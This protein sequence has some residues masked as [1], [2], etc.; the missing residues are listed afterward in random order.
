[1]GRRGTPDDHQ[2]RWVWL[3]GQFGDGFAKTTAEPSQNGTFWCK[4]KNGPHKL[5]AQPP[6]CTGSTPCVPNGSSVSPGGTRLPC[7]GCARGGLLHP[8]LKAPIL[9]RLSTTH[10]LACT[11][12]AAG[13][14]RPPTDPPGLD[15]S[16]CGPAAVPGLV[17]GTTLPQNAKAHWTPL[18]S[19]LEPAMVLSWG[20]VDLDSECPS[21]GGII[22]CW[23]AP[24]VFRL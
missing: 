3:G 8:H 17:P 6:H 15:C 9:V 24:V 18:S 19:R 10:R 13:P 16:R 4:K 20:P 12:I 5:T 21:R 7:C 22:R 11:K 2:G 1:M 23:A 14:W